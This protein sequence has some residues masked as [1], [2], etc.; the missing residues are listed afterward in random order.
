MVREK[1]IVLRTSMIREKSLYIRR[2][3]VAEAPLE[4]SNSRDGK[5]KEIKKSTVTVRLP[6]EIF[7]LSSQKIKVTPWQGSSIPN[8]RAW[9]ALMIHG[10]QLMDGRKAA[11]SSSVLKRDSSIVREFSIYW[12]RAAGVQ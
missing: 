2:G 1:V 10:W 5:E 8:R 3:D 6:L 4:I 9:H 7:Q 12:S 11:K